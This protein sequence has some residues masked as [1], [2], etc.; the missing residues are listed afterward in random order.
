MAAIRR[1]GFSAEVA[2]NGAEALEYL[3]KTIANPEEGEG[4]RRPGIIL[5]D[6]QM[7]VMDGYQCTQA[8]RQSPR[9]QQALK[10]VPII[11]MTASAIQGD[12]EKC[13][14]AGMDDYLS[15]PVQLK[16]LEQKL[17]QWW[18]DRVILPDTSGVEDRDTEQ[19]DVDLPR[20]QAFGNRNT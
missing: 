10:G 19:G 14:A 15:K 20:K 1:V 8:L 17:L 13:I 18:L 2:S 6:V 7:P 12:R 5:M 9:L 4:P 3:N 16:V 11:A